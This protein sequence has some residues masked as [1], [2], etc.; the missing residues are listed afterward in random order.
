MMAIR[1]CRP[2]CPALGLLVALVLATGAA[3]NAQAMEPTAELT[4]DRIALG[5]TAELRVTAVDGRRPALPAVDGLQFSYLGQS[6]EMTSINGTV[7]RHTWVVYQVA[8]ARPGTYTIPIDGQSLALRVE[9]AQSRGAA[10]TPRGVRSASEPP[11]SLAFLRATLPKGKLY[12]GQSV[13]VTFKA[14]FLP[15]TE[16]TLSG[17]PTLGLSAFTISQL[18]E[19]P[20]QSVE[21]VGGVPYRVAT[22]TGLVSAAMPGRYSTNATLPIVARYREPVR[23]PTEDP[24]AGML[25]EDGFPASAMLRSLMN[26]SMFGGG[27][28]DLFGQVRQRQLTLRAPVQAV[29]VLPLPEQGKPADFTG[30]VGRFAIH[31]TLSPSTGTAFEPMSLQVAISGSGTFD[32]VASLGLPAS[33]AWKSYPPSAHFTPSGVAPSLAGTKT[34]EQAVVPQRSG[35]L[36]LPAISFSFFD[37]ERGQYVTRSTT[38]IT[39]QIAA[40]PGGA[41]ATSDPTRAAAA[42]PPSSLR[43]NRLDDGAYVATLLPPYRRAGFW[44]LWAVPWLALALL[45]GWTHLAG[46]RTVRAHR[47]ARDSALAARRLEMRQ[48]VVAQDPVRFI[49]AAAQALQLRLGER[50]GLAPEEVTSA[51]VDSRFGDAGAAVVSALRMAEQ[52]RYAGRMPQLGSLSEYSKTLECEL[53]QL[54]NQS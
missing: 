13:P 45:L 21:E 22:W 16:V 42:T 53:D 9:P 4:P 25:D 2:G 3:G 20:R 47:G 49:A 30:A 36:V 32:R 33:P 8:A 17:A 27:L 52:L 54:E 35:S 12:V 6:T 39:A 5:E 23:R 44:L 24:F 11:D 48:A 19:E 31:A 18:A 40:A 46:R 28:D 10:A 1:K 41:L 15:G 43:P 29:E 38:P 26:R 34:F 37:P 7:S 51:A 14:Y 50:L